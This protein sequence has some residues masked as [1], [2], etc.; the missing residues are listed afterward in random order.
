M[1]GIVA[2]RGNRIWDA[3]RLVSRYVIGG[4]DLIDGAGRIDD[5][6]G[7]NLRGHGE[8][9][10]RIGGAGGDVLSVVRIGGAGEHIMRGDII[11][12]S[13]L[14]SS[15]VKR[16]HGLIHCFLGSYVLRGH[17][18]IHSLCEYSMSGDFIGDVLNE[19]RICGVVNP[20]ALCS[21]RI[22]CDDPDIY[23]YAR[24]LADLND[25]LSG[26]HNLKLAVSVVVGL[27]LLLRLYS[28]HLACHGLL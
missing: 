7:F 26:R 27:T 3:S 18:W 14:V 21:G 23:D 24:I 25:S 22:G 13:R 4:H 17:D 2:L 20:V 28:I 5:V 11:W 12:A 9:G 19:I 8:H 16:V 6:I 10:D 1:I 15:H